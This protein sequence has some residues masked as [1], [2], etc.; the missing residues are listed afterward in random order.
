MMT[1]GRIER[2]G[3]V[4]FGDANISVW[5]EGIPRDLNAKDA[6][7]RKFKIEVF[8]R[9]VQTLNRLGWTC[10]MP[11][12]NPHDIK[13]YGGNVARWSAERRRVCS[14]GEIKGELSVCGRHIEFQMWQGVNTP[15][16]P[17][18]G[19]RYES[20]KEACAP[21]LLRL[22]MERTRRRIRDYLCNVFTDYTFDQKHR[23]I[24]R[25]PLEMTAMERIQQ[26]YAESVHFKG[27][28]GAELAKPY[29]VPDYNRKSADSVLLEHGQRV[30]MADRKGRIV[31][32]IA[33]YNI[34]SMWWVHLGKYDYTNE[35]CSRLYT[36]CP[37]NFRTK[38]NSERRRKRLEGELAKAIKGMNFERAALLRDILFPKKEQLYVV[39]HKEHKAYHRA[40]FQGYTTDV[41]DA[42]KFTEAEV[43]GYTSDPNEVR[44][45]EEAA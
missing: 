22:E 27:D 16:R 4:S 41:I 37:E 44:A 29:G 13:H 31:T 23:S 19:G 8:A 5:E 26:Y 45:L 3:V 25:K 30:W 28:W 12:I 40:N 18:H 11:D 38:R 42:G 6:W 20:D 17:D 34:N 36:K 14:K 9:I 35:S 15:T 39:W 2:E 1:K 7:E 21:Y 24:Y 10:T 32:G 43:K 33:Y